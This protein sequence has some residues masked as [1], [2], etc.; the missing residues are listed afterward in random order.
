[1]SRNWFTLASITVVGLFVLGFCTL[2]Y[3]NGL[4]PIK[5]GSLAALVAVITGAVVK[6]APA[7]K[8]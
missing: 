6:F 3:K 8:E 1:M 7:D 4:D 5:D 2:A